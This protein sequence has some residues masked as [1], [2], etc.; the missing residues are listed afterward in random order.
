MT[1]CG[2]FKHDCNLSLYRKPTSCEPAV[3]QYI[4]D[5]KILPIYP[6]DHKDVGSLFQTVYQ[7]ANSLKMYL[8]SVCI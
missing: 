8:T 1:C 4:P 2:G 6:C 3:T 5:D 7:E